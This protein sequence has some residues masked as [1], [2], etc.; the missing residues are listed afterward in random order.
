MTLTRRLAFKGLA[1][2]DLDRRCRI[3]VRDPPVLDEDAGD[4]I[5]R[6]RHDVGVVE[7]KIT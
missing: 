7:A 2:A 3:I 6:S 4:T 5:R 1:V